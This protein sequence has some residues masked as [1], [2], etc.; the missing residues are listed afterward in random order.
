MSTE[1]RPALEA[2]GWLFL[3]VGL[4]GHVLAAHVG[5]RTIDYQHHTAGFFI[6]L[7][8]TGLPVLALA[9]FW[10]RRRDVTLL[11]VGAIQAVLGILVYL[12]AMAR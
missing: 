11:V 3:V 12:D 6:I 10:R 2:I 9:R 1:E 8:L 4:L 5:G 7:L